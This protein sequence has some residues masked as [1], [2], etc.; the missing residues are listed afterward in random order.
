M[1]NAAKEKENGGSQL[2]VAVLQLDVEL[3]FKLE[4]SLMFHVRPRSGSWTS[5]VL[6]LGELRIYIFLKNENTGGALAFKPV[7]SL[8]NK[9]QKQKHGVLL[10]D[11]V[12]C[13]LRAIAI[14][15]DA[16]RE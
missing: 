11:G 10:Q 16:A 14:N 8:H 15:S 4:C 12:R 1:R 2:A 3:T 7:L 5:N 6:V 13:S 9:I